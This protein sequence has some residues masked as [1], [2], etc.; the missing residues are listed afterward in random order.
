MTVD[1]IQIIVMMLMM[2]VMMNDDD[3]SDDDDDDDDDDDVCCV[4][5]QAF[6]KDTS[7]LS[8]IIA[9][10]HGF[11]MNKNPTPIEDDYDDDS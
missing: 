8:M 7:T 3:D 1:A 9:L 6:S 2:I 5:N 10:L 11:A 4:L